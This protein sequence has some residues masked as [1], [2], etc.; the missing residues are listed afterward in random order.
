[1]KRIFGYILLGSIFAFLAV[2]ELALAV[3]VSHPYLL[4]DNINETIGYQ[5]RTESPW[6]EWEQG[7]KSTANSSLSKNF[8][9]S[10]WAVT[11]F[12]RGQYAQD[13]GLAY[14]ITKNPAYAIKAE[15]ALL[16]ME[17]GSD[18]YPINKPWAL[19]GYAL[20]Y[21]WVQPHTSPE[22]DTIIRDKLANLTDTVYK[23]LN[24]NGADLKY[25]GGADYHGQAYPLVGIA[26]LALYSYTNPNNLSLVS[27]PSDWLKAGTDYLFIDDKLHYYNRSLLSFEY[28]D[29]GKH[30][31]GAYKGYEIEEFV[32]WFQ[33]YSHF[34]G[35]N[36]LDE[37]PLL[38]NI[39]TSE[40]WESMPNH[41]GNNYITASNVKWIYHD[42]IM[43]LL[44]DGNKSYVLNHI[45]SV[46]NSAELPYSYAPEYLTTG[47]Y[48][49][50]YNNYSSIPRTN[51]LWTS[52]LDPKSVYQ[53]FREDWNKD[54]DWLSFITWN[55]ETTMNRNMAHHDQMS[56][57]YYSKGDLLLADAGEL[58]Y[59]LSPKNPYFSG[60]VGQMYG[61]YDIFHN[62]ILIENPRAPF[63]ASFWANSAARGIYKGDATSLKTLAQ[64][65]NIIQ[66]P[67]MEL[68]KA[69]TTI[70]SVIDTFSNKKS[71]SSNIS[72]SREIIY[73]NKD[74]FTIIDKLNGSETWTYR[75]QFRFTS[76]S[77]M[78]TI[79]NN[80]DKNYSED[81][82]GNVSGALTIGNTSYNW[83]LLPYNVE[84]VTGINTSSIIWDTTNPYGNAVTLHLFSV[85][86]SE[87][88]LTKHLTRIG[89]VYSKSEVFNPI[90]YFRTGNTASLYR[91]T[92]LLTRYSSEEEK[93]P[94]EVAVTGTGNAIKVTSSAYE[95]Y[96]YS[97]K[98]ASS[99]GSFATDADTL[100][101]RKTSEPFEYT[102]INGSYINYSGNPLITLSKKADYLTL[103]KDAKNTTFTI[104]G[105]GM[106][107]ITLKGTGASNYIVKRDGVKYTG[108]VKSGTDLIISADL[109]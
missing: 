100:Y 32:W 51:P 8:S 106:V 76:L 37:Y 80:D 99:F 105:E 66:T 50:F 62:V 85:P 25:V 107:N 86:S 90:V 26:G 38:K 67:W 61:T 36:I 22:N 41:Y 55:K 10:N 16:N 64:I 68:I 83:Q 3:P 58:K 48:Y 52:H 1:M 24:K 81:E 79:D 75:N 9:N 23:E 31:S 71:L 54:G 60:D 102:L 59:T 14:Q 78:P 70:I 44:D 47:I 42:G 5:H 7:L 87:I 45:D 15:E 6:K 20:A 65:K 103:E 27:A 21:D 28:D 33:A 95:D 108:F 101:I 94:A 72:Y 109:S 98:G 46:K 49:L 34:F 91:M 82:I 4:F 40:L 92:V 96:I 17:L 11:M 30:L 73:P 93:I 88:L 63:Q 35:K 39:V 12:N 57:E 53:V 43:N 18:P 13:L 84:T 89:G 56:F 29:A 69:N 74:Y 19:R 2:Q 104:D 97:G 77:I